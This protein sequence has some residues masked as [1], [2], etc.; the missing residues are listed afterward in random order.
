MTNKNNDLVIFQMDAAIKE[1][2][3][4]LLIIILLPAMAVYIT[5]KNI[6]NYN[7]SICNKPKKIYFFLNVLLSSFTVFFIKYTKG[8]NY[9]KVAKLFIEPYSN[10]KYFFVCLGISILFYIAIYI[11]YKYIKQKTYFNNDEFDVFN[12]ERNSNYEL[13]R[14]ISILMIILFHLTFHSWY[15][16]DNSTLSMARYT[17]QVFMYLGELGVNLFAL[18]T[19]FYLVDSKFKLK[20]FINIVIMILF[21]SYFGLLVSYYFNIEIPN[22]LI[23]SI[24]PI[25]K[26]KYWYAT[27]YLILYIFTPY[28]KIA[29]SSTNKQ[30][31]KKKIIL[32]IIIWSVIPSIFGFINNNTENFL[33]YNR[34]IWIYIMYNI[35]YYIR[36]FT[37]K[38][39]KRLKFY[40]RCLILSVIVLLISISFLDYIGIKYVFFSDRAFFLW[41]PNSIL[42]LIM[43]CS[44]FMIFGYI[45]IINRYI[46]Y[47][48][49]F[50]FGVY[51]FHD[52]DYIRILLL[53]IIFNSKQYQNNN[54]LGIYLLMITVFVYLLSLVIETIRKHIF[55]KIFDKIRK[56]ISSLEK[57]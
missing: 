6:S 15:S 33:F 57:F 36:N 20:K 2:L 12:S 43:S 3:L 50:T 45:K 7:V 4:S 17:A 48:A 18:I 41:T 40:S 53:N 52:N 46:N 42:L 13:L 47:V 35:G 38:S 51:L 39:K 37:T 5:V 1:L 30:L 32:M 55:E 31:L 24:F 10:L 16:Y 9:S 14:I 28:I 56:K 23:N 19:G 22:N 34:L 11:Y 26:G 29:L 25:I 8:Y 44:L 21:Y 27:V 49:S 54:K